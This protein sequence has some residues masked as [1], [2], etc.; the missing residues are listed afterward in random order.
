MPRDLADL[1]SRLRAAT[2]PVEITTSSGGVMAFDSDAVRAASERILKR[3]RI[4]ADSS[5]SL[6]GV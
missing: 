3:Y 4:V 5:A 1:A 6:S 2:G